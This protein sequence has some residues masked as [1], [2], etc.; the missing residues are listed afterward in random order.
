[1]GEDEGYLL[2][3][4]LG[5]TTVRAVLFDLAGQPLAAAYREPRLYH[6]Q[7]AWAELDVEDWWQ[8]SVAVI[9]ETLG[10]ARVDPAQICGIGLS[11]LLHALIPVDTQGEPLDRPMLW[12]DQRCAPQVEW[13][14]REYRAVLT[15]IMGPQPVSTT[16]SAPKLRWLVENRPQMVVDTRYFLSVKDFVRFRLTGHF[17]AEPTDAG[18]TYLFDRAR[19]EWSPT[20]LEIVGIRGDQMP[21]LFPSTA[22]AGGVLG[23]VAA[24]TGL[25]QGTPVV[26]GGGDT[27]CTRIGAN[28]AGTDRPCL[29]LGTAAWLSVPQPREM[30]FGATATTGAT[31]KWLA[32]LFDVDSKPSPGAGYQRLLQGVDSVPPGAHG[33]L[34]L[35]HLMGER[36]PAPNPDAVG[37]FFGLTL[38][39]GRPELTR[40]V[41][42]GCGFHLRTIVESLSP[43]PLAEIVVTGGGA[44]SRLW[45]QILADILGSDLRVPA[46]VE[47]AALGAAILAGVGVG[48]YPDTRTASQQLVDLRTIVA[49]DAAHR[50]RYERFFT[51]YQ[52]LEHRLAPLYT[53]T[54]TESFSQ[55]A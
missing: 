41:L 15:P 39:H 38:A 53:H 27:F 21:P 49:P 35:P 28:V 29:Y 26:M 37:V 50:Q 34:F 18:G 32:H 4:D 1:M 12:M 36:G 23:A 45:L 44:K 3:L 42:E 24:L 8:S 33:L 20:L 10:A 54:L 6:P 11:G 46:Q 30:A 16:W 25:A 55:L 2:G 17:G 5:T 13:M 51:R 22:L 7:P 47:S 31:L 52:K 9:R 19:Q 40:A 14:E 43:T 48:I